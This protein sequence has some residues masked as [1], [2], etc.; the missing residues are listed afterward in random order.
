M[1]SLPTLLTIL[2]C[3]GVLG[4]PD[5][6]VQDDDSALADDDDSQDTD[7][8]D[9]D[10]YSPAEGDCDDEDPDVHP[11]A[12]EV[13]DGLDNDCDGAIDEDFGEPL[14]WHADAD[15]DGYGDPLAV[16]V[17]ACGQ[18]AGTVEDGTDCDDGDPDVHPGAPDEPCDGVDGDCDGVGDE[19]VAEH[20][21]TEYESVQLA[22]DAAPDGATVHVCPGTHVQRILIGD[23]RQLELTS[24][25]G[26]P[27]DTVL[28]GDEKWTILYI[29]YSAEVTVSHLTFEHGRAE[30]WY[31]GDGQY[32]GAITSE[33]V[34]LLVSDCVFEA[35]WAH[36]SGGAMSVRSMFIL[37]RM[38]VARIEGCV[39]VDNHAGYEAGAV[40]FDTQ[41]PY[42]FELT[43]SELIDNGSGY[44]GGAIKAS[45]FTGDSTAELV[46]TDCLFDG[47][48]AGY[49][50]GVLDMSG[51]GTWKLTV[52]GT[53]FT[54]N[55]TDAG[56]LEVGSANT[57]LDATFQQTVI[58][59]NDGPAIR[60]NANNS[61]TLTLTDCTVT[62]N[63]GQSVGAVEL[64]SGHVLVSD[65][66]DWGSGGQDNLP[67]D[68][69]TGPMQYTAFG[70]GESF[71][72]TGGGLCQ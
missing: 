49:E 12:E 37:D 42:L 55:G 10:G 34:D 31:P 32:G 40:N 21:G 70:A 62:G 11:G 13:C 36:Y 7:D 41:V 17:T 44:D 8:L 54:G 5:D 43:D 71:T 4:C 58:D 60:T 1:R 72:C 27:T 9:G 2:L 3:L 51:S 61:G 57:V 69:S 28:D 38:P 22:I 29:G 48:Q 24:W 59:A 14:D 39:F 16:T 53:T 33:A 47:N 50:G 45:N 25:S 67:C 66:T 56:V 52:S 26:D 15:G 46:I 6:D 63:V 20:G 23:E 19:E 64:G 65:N 30:M 18:P 68:I 35:N